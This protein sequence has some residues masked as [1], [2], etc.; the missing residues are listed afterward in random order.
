MKVIYTYKFKVI[1][2]V[3]FL[4]AVLC[5]VITWM[6]IIGLE[7]A[8]ID[9][10]LQEGKMIVKEASDCIEVKK[11]E[12]LSLSLDKTDSYYEDLN[13][14]LYDVRERYNCQYLY[15]M[16]PSGDGIH[17]TYVV[18]GS[19]IIDEENEDFSPLG[20][21]EDITSYG[22][23]PWDCLKTKAITA[24]RLIY[25]DKWGWSIS[26]Y[27]PIINEQNE[28]VGFTAVD[29]DANALHK[30]VLV[31]TAKVILTTIIGVIIVLGILLLIFIRFF[32]HMNRVV[33]RMEEISGGGSDLT[34]RIGYTKQN[35]IGKL[36][37][38]CNLVIE[39]IQKM[40]KTVSG[41]VGSLSSNSTEILEQSNK[42]VT[43]VGEA[44]SSIAVI[45]DKAENQKELVSGLTSE[46]QNFK[47]SIDMFQNRVEKQVDAVNRS[48]AAI[49]QITANISSAD[50]NITRI[51]GEYSVIVNETNQN[52]SNQKALSQQIAHIQSLASNLFEANKIISSIAGQTNLLAMN[53]A[54]ESAHAGAAGAG[55]SVVAEEIRKLAETSSEQTK[56]IKTIVAEIEGAVGD[57]VDSS[58]KSEAAF[59]KL[60][61]KV[62]TLQS[63]VQE[64]QR[65]MNEQATGARE[66]LDMMKVLNAASSEMAASSQTMSDKTGE[67]VNSMQE[68]NTSSS[69]ILD[70]TGSTSEKLRNIKMFAEEASETSGS[71]EKLA[72][73]VTKIVG[74]YKV[75]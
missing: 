61:E 1:A 72:E 32:K 71:N 12:N 70:S 20:L 29:F 19:V 9:T 68:I 58:N 24:S 66:I 52:L 28:A 46:I 2:A 15:T 63:S 11:W 35:E 26:V 22:D 54:I 38:A 34:A 55:F 8:A 60:G 37:N 14:F 33:V 51:S 49:E 21:V 23:A 31:Q 17:A 27:K 13:E 56:S 5:G 50:Q 36:A 44:E 45:E 42:M 39:T 57:M 25:D 3:A 41:S 43:M 6:G 4:M 30:T 10:F 7:T 75:D 73:E 40:V 64:I 62:D 16:R 59:S 48:S 67:I 18:D 69:D 47:N 74:S 65:G 53:A